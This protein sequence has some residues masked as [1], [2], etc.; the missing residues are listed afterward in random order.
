MGWLVAQG[1][2]NAHGILGTVSGL[3]ETQL[4]SPVITYPLVTKLGIVRVLGLCSEN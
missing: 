4:M 2:V 3:Q 1:Q